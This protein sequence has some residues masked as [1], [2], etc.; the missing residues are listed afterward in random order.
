MYIAK[1][2]FAVR[3]TGGGHKVADMSLTIMIF[4]TPSLREDMDIT[5][6]KT[7]K[8]IYTVHVDDH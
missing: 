5:N 1:T 6:Y 7:T 4:L 2:V 3:G 8:F